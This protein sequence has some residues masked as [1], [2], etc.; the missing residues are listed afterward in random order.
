[1]MS[2]L[3]FVQSFCFLNSSLNSGSFLLTLALQDY[4]VPAIKAAA[5][6]P[7][8]KNKSITYEISYSFAQIC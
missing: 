6:K 3:T 2:C 5:V 1:M 7:E 4:I 8:Y